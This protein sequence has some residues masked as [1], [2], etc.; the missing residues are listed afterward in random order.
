MPRFHLDRSFVLFFFT[1]GVGSGA[2]AA[3]VPAWT[4]QARL[5][6]LVPRSPDPLEPVLAGT[7]AVLPDTLDTSS[8]PLPV[9]APMAAIPHS[10]VPNAAAALETIITTGLLTAPG[11]VAAAAASIPTTGLLT[12][13]AASEVSPVVEAT[14]V[15]VTVA[16]SVSLIDHMLGTHGSENCRYFAGRVKLSIRSYFLETWEPFGLPN[17][18]VH[19][20]F[21]IGGLQHFRTVPHRH[22]FRPYIISDHRCL[23]QHPI[24]DLDGKFRSEVVGAGTLGMGHGGRSGR[25]CSF[26]RSL[27]PFS[28]I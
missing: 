18:G 15:S 19:L 14:S 8:S 27:T 26:A 3:H 24:Y 5:S 1:L 17:V 16:P 13:P 7:E 10:I 22:R 20:S 21:C 4:R 6:H 11:T 9:V 28:L 12:A 25:K 23:D 2:L